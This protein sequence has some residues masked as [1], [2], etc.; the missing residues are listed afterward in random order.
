MLTLILGLG[1]LF[2]D[3]EKFTPIRKAFA[4]LWIL[5]I[6]TLMIMCV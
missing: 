1:V 5:T 4:M 3:D 6:D 2:S